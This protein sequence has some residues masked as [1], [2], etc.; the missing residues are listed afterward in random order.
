MSFRMR[1]TQLSPPEI[2]IYKKEEQGH[3]QKS[4]IY[5]QEDIDLI[6]EQYKEKEERVKKFISNPTNSL[7]EQYKKSLVREEPNFDRETIVYDKTTGK[8][9]LMKEK[10]VVNS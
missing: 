4:K 3:E 7:M 6:D 5:T 1:N 10:H 2:V 9:K 8:W